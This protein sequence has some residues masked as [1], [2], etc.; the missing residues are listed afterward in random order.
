[1]A[2]LN[3]TIQAFE[4]LENILDYISKDSVSIAKSFVQSIIN[5]AEILEIFPNS[6]RIVPEINKTDLR[7]LIHGNYRIIYK[8]Y[9]DKIDIIT[10]YHSARLLKPEDF[11]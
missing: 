1:M 11:N 7:E 6:G 10:I 4:D 2:K 8:V 3:F 5:K 9:D